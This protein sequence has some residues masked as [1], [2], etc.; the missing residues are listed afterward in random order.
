MAFPPNTKA[1]P[2]SK[3]DG[4]AG[5]GAAPG[6]AASGGSSSSS[7]SASESDSNASESKM[8]GAK[9]NPLRKWAAAGGSTPGGASGGDY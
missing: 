2:F 9:M 4:G 3:K 1:P 7:D 6:A 5:P 8:K